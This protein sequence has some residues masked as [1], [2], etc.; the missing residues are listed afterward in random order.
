[1]N[2]N[3]SRIKLILAS[4]TWLYALAQ[5]SPEMSAQITAA[6]TEELTRAGSV[7]GEFTAKLYNKLRPRGLRRYPERKF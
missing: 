6:L 1:L 3:A 5:H 2:A 7:S 4:D